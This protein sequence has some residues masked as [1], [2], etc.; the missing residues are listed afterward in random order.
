MALKPR[1]LSLVTVAL[2]C[3]A[4]ATAASASPS[5]PVTVVLYAPGQSP[6]TDST[7]ITQLE[8]SCPIATSA[9]PT[10]Y[11]AGG[12]P[13]PAIT[14]NTSDMWAVATLLTAPGCLP[15]ACR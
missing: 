6:T 1:L 8:S 14:A 15:A 4:S 9:E 2:A 11:G 13:T 5:S 12:S 10:L 3:L 7:T